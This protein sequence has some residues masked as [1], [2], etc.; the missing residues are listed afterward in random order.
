MLSLQVI[1]C[2]YLSF[3]SA[4]LRTLNFRQKIADYSWPASIDDTSQ[5][6]WNWKHEFDLEI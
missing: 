6:G 2:H 5:R 1:G 3:K 4:T